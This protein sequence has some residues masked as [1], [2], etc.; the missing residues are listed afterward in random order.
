[1]AKVISFDEVPHKALGKLFAVIG[2]NCNHRRLMFDGK[3]VECR[4]C[5]KVWK[6]YL[7]DAARGAKK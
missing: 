6:D 2:N 5:G 4:T 3:S 7:G 1:M